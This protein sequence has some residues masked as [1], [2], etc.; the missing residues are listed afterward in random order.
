M[1]YILLWL[2]QKGAHKL[3][4]TVPWWRNTV[5]ESVRISLQFSAAG[6]Q[7]PV[8]SGVNGRCTVMKGV[9]ILACSNGLR[10]VMSHYLSPFISKL[11]VVTSLARLF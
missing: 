10:E 2:V 11:V 8:W 3:T 6:R 4:H 1:F 9:S 5:S 7:S